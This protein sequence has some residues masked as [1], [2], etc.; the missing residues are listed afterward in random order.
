MALIFGVIAVVMIKVGMLAQYGRT[1]I[2]SVVAG[3]IAATVVSAVLLA[4]R[5]A[6]VNRLSELRTWPQN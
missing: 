5:R 4:L 2:L 1:F 3:A 6:G